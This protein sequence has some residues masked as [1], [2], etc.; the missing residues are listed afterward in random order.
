MVGGAVAGKISG[1]GLTYFPAD[2]II[3]DWIPRFPVWGWACAH[4]TFN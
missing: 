1:N 4:R 2:Y 3:I